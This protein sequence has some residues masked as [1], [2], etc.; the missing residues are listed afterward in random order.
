M[1]KNPLPSVIEKS[2]GV[3]LYHVCNG[4]R[5]Y[6]LLHYPSGHWD[7]P[8]GHVEEQDDNEIATADRELEEE[9]GITDVE[10]L[11]DFREAMYYEFNRGRKECVKKTVVYFVAEAPCQ[12][13]KISFE[14][15]GFIWMPYDAAMEKLTFGNAKELLLKAE[16][17]LNSKS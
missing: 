2:C 14:H 3:I 10:Y 8:K 15:K 12:D 7:Y 13:V 11:P 5:E 16:D 6:L 4:I 17:H 1:N 9:T